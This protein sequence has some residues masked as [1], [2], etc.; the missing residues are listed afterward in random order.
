MK[1]RRK[2]DLKDKKCIRRLGYKKANQEKKN[3]MASLVLKF[4]NHSS[5]LKEK[6]KN[7]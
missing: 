5:K 4:R 7:Y 3:V 6:I 1:S 2:L